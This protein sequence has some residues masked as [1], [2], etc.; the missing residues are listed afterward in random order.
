[1]NPSD[2]VDMECDCKKKLVT[3]DTDGGFL[4]S[5]GSIVSDAAINWDDDPRYGI[6]NYR[7]P[8][9]AQVDA[10][11]NKI[12]ISGWIPGTSR[13]RCLKN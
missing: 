3:V 1:M 10:D 12:D 4:G 8:L 11:Q 6:G 2:C 5:P 7:I 13:D 9:T